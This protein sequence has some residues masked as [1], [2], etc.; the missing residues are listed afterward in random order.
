MQLTDKKLMQL[1]NE[2][3]QWDIHACTNFESKYAEMLNSEKNS[4]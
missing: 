3:A 1:H 2:H 4:Y